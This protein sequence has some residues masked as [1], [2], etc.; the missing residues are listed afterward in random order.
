MLIH[1]CD[2]W[3]LYIGAESHYNVGC[4]FVLRKRSI[5]LLFLALRKPNGDIAVRFC[6]GMKHHAQLEKEKSNF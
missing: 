2:Y 1:V 5:L 3:A 4:D 6:H